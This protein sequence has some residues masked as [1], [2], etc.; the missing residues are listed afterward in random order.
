MKFEAE[1]MKYLSYALYHLCI[2]A[3]VYSLI[4]EP[5]KRFEL[6]MPLKKKP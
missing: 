3:A 1:C 4:Y 5:Q 6:L 2:C